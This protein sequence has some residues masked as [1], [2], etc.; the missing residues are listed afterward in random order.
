[1]FFPF[2]SYPEGQ[3]FLLISPFFFSHSFAISFYTKMAAGWWAHYITAHSLLKVSLTPSHLKIKCPIYMQL[4]L[5]SVIS[6]DLMV[7]WTGDWVE[8]ICI[9]SHCAIEERGGSILHEPSYS[10]IIIGVVLKHTLYFILGLFSHSFVIN[11]GWIQTSVSNVSTKKCI[12]DNYSFI[13]ISKLCDFLLQTT[14]N[15]FCPYN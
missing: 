15:I 3:Y 12:F 4:K 5:L 13:V 14:E 1:M 8:G 10:I 9:K 7:K 6:P 2:Y 11:T